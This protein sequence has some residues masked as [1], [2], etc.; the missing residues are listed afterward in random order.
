MKTNPPVVAGCTDGIGK[1]YTLELTRRGF[2]KFIFVSRSVAK[3]EALRDEVLRIN[4]S[5]QIELLR[6]DFDTDNYETLDAFPWHVY[7]V[8]L[9]GK[10]FCCTVRFIRMVFF[11]VNSIGLPP[12]GLVPF[13]EQGFA[14]AQRLFRV[15]VMATV[16]VK[17]MCICKITPS[18]R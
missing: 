9:L 5:V 17:R 3:L 18:F 12:E 16:K 4:S 10:C 6:F 8:G 7:D 1:A 13:A 15:N 11:I 14:N 2:N